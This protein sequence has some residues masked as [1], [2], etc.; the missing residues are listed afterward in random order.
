MNKSNYFRYFFV[1]NFQNVKLLIERKILATVITSLFLNI[2]Q[3][4]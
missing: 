1:F 4:L 2:L 3:F